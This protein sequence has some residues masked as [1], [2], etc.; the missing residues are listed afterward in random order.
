MYNHTNSEC[1]REKERKL[2]HQAGIDSSVEIYLHVMNS[3]T[4]SPGEMKKWIR[5]P[6][7]M[8]AKNQLE[9]TPCQKPMME[10]T[11]TIYIC[12]LSEKMYSQSHSD[13]RK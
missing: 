10:I 5:E 4:H 6:D 3:E 9:N 12:W 8:N 13:T 11:L 7:D 2:L 1:V